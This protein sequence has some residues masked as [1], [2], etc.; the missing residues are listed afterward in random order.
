M[1]KD[2]LWLVHSWFRRVGAA[3]ERDVEAEAWRLYQRLRYA[4]TLAPG[5]IQSPIGPVATDELAARVDEAARRVLADVD[6]FNARAGDGEMSRRI[7]AGIAWLPV[8]DA[9]PSGT[10]SPSA[11]R[12]L[13]RR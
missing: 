6:A 10:G 1:T 12:Q 2:R 3:A 8:V 13:A 4:T 11:A 7:E 9:A 5:I